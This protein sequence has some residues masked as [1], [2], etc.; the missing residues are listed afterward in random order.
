MF[1]TLTQIRR[2]KMVSAAEG[3]FHSLRSLIRSGRGEKLKL[4]ELTEE[5]S[6]D[7]TTEVCSVA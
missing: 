7:K 5:T 2:E 1:S 3:I 4:P 6:S